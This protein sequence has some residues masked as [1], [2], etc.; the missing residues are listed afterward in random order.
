MLP[1]TL[2]LKL[3]GRIKKLVILRN[4]L[5]GVTSVA[6][7]MKI[8]CLNNGRLYPIVVLVMTTTTLELL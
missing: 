7:R 6:K 1:W 4:E 8:I 2:S 5:I 3:G